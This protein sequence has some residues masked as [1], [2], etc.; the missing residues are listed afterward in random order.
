MM[1]MKLC[2]TDAS[3]SVLVFQTCPGVP[4]RCFRH[5][6]NLIA[7]FQKPGQGIAMP[8]LYPVTAQRRAR[9]DR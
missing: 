1:M 3:S 7:A 2:L 8:L 9:I 5:I 6:R 4:K